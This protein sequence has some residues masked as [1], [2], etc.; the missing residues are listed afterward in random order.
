MHFYCTFG[1]RMGFPYPSSRHGMYID[2]N[3]TT[4]TA[5]DV[6]LLSRLVVELNI[7]RRNFR[8]YPKDHP[9]IDASFTKVIDIYNQLLSQEKEVAIAVARETLMLNDDVLD[10]NNLV[11]RDFARVLFEHGIGVLILRRGLS[12]AEL[13]NFNIILSLKREEL[14][15]YGGIAPVW[16]KANITSLDIKAIRYDLFNVIENPT[17]TGE[18]AS[19]GLWER[20]ARGLVRDTLVE[21]DME[22]AEIDPRL[23][24]SILN[25]HM[26]VADHGTEHG[27]SDN[28]ISTFIELTLDDS[29]GDVRGAIPY[30]KL[31][32]FISNLNPELRRQFLSSSFDISNLNGGSLSEE[33]FPRL[34]REA[35]LETL[36]DIAQKRFNVPPVMMRLL[37]RMSLNTDQQQSSAMPSL[38]DEKGIHQKIRSIFREHDSENF[39]PDS[40]RYALDRIIVTEHTQRLEHVVIADLMETLD[41]HCIENHISDIILS[42][43]VLDDDPDQVGI[44]VSNLSE[45]YFYLLQ[46][47]DYDQLIRLIEQCDA[48]EVPAAVRDSLR[49]NYTS[50]EC[51]EEMLVGLTTWGKAKFDDITSLIRIIGEPFIEVLLDRLAEEE[52][53]SLRRFL[54]D[55]VQEFGPLAK[56]AI[57][58]RLADKR[59]FVLRNLV[60]MLRMLDDITV[61]EHIRPLLHNSNHRV[62]Q[63]T[64]RTFLHYHDPAAER[65]V[66]YDMD[67]P[68]RETQLSAIYLA[69]KSRSNDVFKKLLAIVAKPGFSSIECELKSAAVHTLAEIGRADALPELA[70]VL[71]SKSLL[72][73]RPLTKLKID[74]VRS[75]GH[76]PPAI[77]KPIMEKLTAG[78]GEVARQAMVSL[79]LI[80]GKAP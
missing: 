18:Q 12:A 46:T 66:L 37:Q 71:A 32:L 17:E 51:L 73:T 69:E 7:A 27:F 1:P 41:A 50:R 25:R 64:L 14:Q 6:G 35:V 11:F 54:T 23:L 16:E 57:I 60:I 59:W 28:A 24:A 36:E 21:E 15:K 65:Q 3:S 75:L 39:I 72:N 4:A 56:D 30:E 70:K 33:L 77:A 78:S 67:S 10:K 49:R 55:R 5:T 20:F 63:E 47:G 52:S 38:E 26:G 40:Y 80:S 44:L 62:R 53:I 31:A 48:Q 34:A 42:M 43:I 19:Q 61:L 2:Q 29:R 74:I 9:V 45:M 8:S 13:R 68:D 76:Y 22:G 79:K 58:A